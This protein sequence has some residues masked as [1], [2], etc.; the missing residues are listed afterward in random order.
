MNKELA[1]IDWQKPAQTVHD[2]VRGFNAW[3]I[4][5]SLIKG[6]K[7]KVY[8]TEMTDVPAEG[9][10]GSVV[11][12]DKDGMMV[13][14]SD[15]QLLVKEVQMPNKKRMR[16]EQYILGNTIEVNTILGE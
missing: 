6:Q 1:V 11:S 5:T 16:I 3:P 13:N 9:Q 10:A 7:I 8:V 2:L 14:C 12:V 15:Y 4:A